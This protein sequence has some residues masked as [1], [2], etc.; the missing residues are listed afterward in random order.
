[1]RARVDQM[2]AIIQRQQHRPRPQCLGE[3]LN[4]RAPPLLVH[5]DDRRHPRDDKI[6]LAH[7]AELDEP[8]SVREIAG[9]RREN[10]QSQPRL[11]DAASPA[12]R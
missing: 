1:M 4:Q 5:A 8:G 6:R 9:E 2:L 10:A 3:R 7:V 12:Q 11:P